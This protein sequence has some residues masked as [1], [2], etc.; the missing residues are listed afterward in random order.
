MGAEGSLGLRYPNPGH[1]FLY[2]L[3]GF[4][5]EPAQ[6]PHRKN[7]F[8]MRLKVSANRPNSSVPALCT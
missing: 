3:D 4:L 1:L 7:N 2:P 6:Q 5:S 8:V